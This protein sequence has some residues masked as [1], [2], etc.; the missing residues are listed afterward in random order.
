MLTRQQIE[1]AKR[2]TNY[3]HP[4]NEVYHE[5]DDCIR[6]AYDWLD[7]QPKRKTV[8]YRKWVSKHEVETWAGRYI[9]QSD[10]EVAA[11]LH[12]A[13]VGRYPYFNVGSRRLLPNAASLLGKGV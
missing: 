5:H 13:V 1:A 3:G 10:V 9:S 2:R 6:L 4:A 7:A 12:P 11:E 8:N